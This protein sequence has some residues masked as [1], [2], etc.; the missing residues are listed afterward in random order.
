VLGALGIEEGQSVADIGAGG[1]YFTYRIARAVGPEGR[2]YDVE[3][4]GDMRTRIRDH[5]A[6]QGHTNIFTVEADEGG[7]ASAV[8]SPSR[9][10]SPSS[11]V[12]T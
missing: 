5:A 3:P 2:V 10:R 11:R 7:G 12:T 4:D 9:R 1:G 6:R 8:T